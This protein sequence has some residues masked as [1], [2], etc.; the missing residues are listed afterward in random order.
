[1]TLCHCRRAS[2]RRRLLLRRSV[3]LSRWSLRSRPRCRS[4]RVMLHRW[5]THWVTWTHWP[6]L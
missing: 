1:L 4:L 5:A 2:L 6:I 3:L